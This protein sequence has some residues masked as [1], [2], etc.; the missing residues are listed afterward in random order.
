MGMISEDVIRG[1]MEER[2]L[3]SIM[4]MNCLL[5]LILPGHGYTG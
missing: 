4:E 2:R 3:Q 1:A 5:I